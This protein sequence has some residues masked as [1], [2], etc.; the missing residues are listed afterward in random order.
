VTVA[1]VPIPERIANPVIRPLHYT[2][3]R[4][5]FLEQSGEPEQRI[6]T[7]L[8]SMGRLRPSLCF[9]PISKGDL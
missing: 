2:L 1:V 5:G 4:S 3:P 6:G 8:K 9:T 7:V